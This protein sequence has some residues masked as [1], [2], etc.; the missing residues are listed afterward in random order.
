MKRK[1]ETALQKHNSLMHKIWAT[2]KLVLPVEFII[3]CSVAWRGRISIYLCLSYLVYVE[4]MTKTL[5]IQ[6]SKSIDSN[7]KWKLTTQK[8]NRLWFYI[9][10]SSGAE[11]QLS[12]FRKQTSA[13]F[14]L[15]KQETHDRI[16]RVPAKWEK[17]LLRQV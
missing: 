6:T 13:P 15:C 7:L 10:I 8:V 11:I 12:N 14:V 1:K 4:M 5:P 9:Y 16:L 17:L 3:K 2:W